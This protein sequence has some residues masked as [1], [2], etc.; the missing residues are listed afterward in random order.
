MTVL[1]E[2]L[3]GLSKTFSGEPKSAHTV[4]IE[5][6]LLPAVLKLQKEIGWRRYKVRCE[7]RNCIER[8]DLFQLFIDRILCGLRSLLTLSC[9]VNR[10]AKLR[11]RKLSWP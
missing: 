1:S 10:N 9:L 7:L 11:Y 6:Q 8:N 5:S 4:F 2:A 3:A